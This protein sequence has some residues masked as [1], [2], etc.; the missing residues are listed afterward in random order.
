MNRSRRR[1]TV[2]TWAIAAS[3]LHGGV[4]LVVAGVAAADPA[5]SGEPAGDRGGAERGVRHEG[6]H[7]DARPTGT[8]AV[9]RRPQAR[10]TALGPAETARVGSRGRPDTVA[11][12][13]PATG[14][15][16]GEVPEEWPCPWWP[17]IWPDIH[18]PLRAA[19][20][21]RGFTPVAN[22]GFA[23]ALAAAYPAG[24][25]VP[26]PGFGPRAPGE[27]FVDLSPVTTQPPDAAAGAPAGP[28][29]RASVPL[30]GPP[31]APPRVAPLSGPPGPSVGAPPPLGPDSLGK[32][33]ESVLPGYQESLR[34]AD[35]GVLAAAALPGLAAIAGLTA[36]GGFLGYRQARAGY[37]LRAASAGRFLQ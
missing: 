17:I 9:T 7:R 35:V 1:A 12:T 10:R 36:L 22:D 16:A 24:V 5:A 23:L 6:A 8:A 31:A 28:A 33:S 15:P 27:Y 26:L 20:D 18:P 19:H 13:D 32:P 11:Q 4:G 37:L 2:I 25:P 34:A 29:L 3:V 21:P 30:A 14:G